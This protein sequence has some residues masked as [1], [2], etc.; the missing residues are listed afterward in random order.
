MPARS[1]APAAAALLLLALCA[2]GSAEDPTG[3]N[4]S[5]KEAGP[6][7][8]DESCA[9]GKLGCNA[10]GQHVQCRFCGHGQYTNNCPHTMCTFPNEPQTAYFWDPTCQV[11]QVGCWA[12][13]IHHECRFC[14][15]PS[16][17][18]VECPAWASSAPLQACD[19]DGEPEASYYWEQTCTESML[20]C[21]ADGKHVGCRYCGGDGD[22]S[23]IMCPGGRCTFSNDPQVPYYWEPDCRE[24]ILGCLADG[25]HVQCRFCE[26]RPYEDVRCPDGD[27]RK[28]PEGQCH[29]PN[30]PKIAYYWDEACEMGKLGCWADGIHAKCRFCGS[31]A[32]ESILCPP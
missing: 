14:G 22:Y 29:F 7:Y 18:A 5:S 31:G 6:H 8:W 4:F 11:G 26:M 16:F 25:I 28:P 21:K 15:Y 12:D 2:V 10:D 27:S 32:F 3:C 13:G 1:L 24:G 30:E 17:N 19:F 20:G 23:G 9:I